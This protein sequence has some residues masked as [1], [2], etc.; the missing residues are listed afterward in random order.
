MD[1]LIHLTGCPCSGKTWVMEEFK[2]HPLIA[3]WD[4]LEWYQKNQLIENKQINWEKWNKVK[5]SAWE[6]FKEFLTKN[7]DKP[8]I[9]LESSGHNQLL[10]KNLK[11]IKNK[12]TVKFV[13]PDENTVIERC[14]TR[15]T[16]DLDKT[17]NLRDKYIYSWDKEWERDQSIELQPYEVGLYIQSWIDSIESNYNEL[18][19]DKKGSNFNHYEY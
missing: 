15:D 2:N 13:I 4:I 17:L 6:D 12:A 11:S 19:V 7:N 1:V 18:A 8:I 5:D 10:N 14:L 16:T 3:T 9:I